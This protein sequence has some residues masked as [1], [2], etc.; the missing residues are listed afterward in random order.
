[1]VVTEAMNAMLEETEYLKKEW[2]LLHVV[3]LHPYRSLYCSLQ[4]RIY[5][6]VPTWRASTCISNAYTTKWFEL[7]GVNGVSVGFNDGYEVLKGNYRR[8]PV[9]LRS[10]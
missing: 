2:E 3:A 1:M 9:L 5:S 7:L 6:R 4:V 8:R 10:A